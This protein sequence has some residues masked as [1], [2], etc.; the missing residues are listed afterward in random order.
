MPNLSNDLNLDKETHEPD[1]QSHRNAPLHRK[2]SG[3]KKIED[4][5]VKDAQLIFQTVWH[6]LEPEMGSENLKFPAE[7]FWLKYFC[8]SSS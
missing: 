6:E 3:S 7:I 8:T 4:L 2:K 5:E 1:S